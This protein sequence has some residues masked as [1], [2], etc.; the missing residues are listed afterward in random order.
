MGRIIDETG[1]QYGYWTVIKRLPRD[2][3]KG[4]VRWLCKCKCGTEKSICGAEL[5]RGR[6]KSCGC[7][8]ENNIIGQHFGRL[9]VLRKD[10]S[11]SQKVICQCD[12][13]AITSVYKGHL[14]TGA[15]TS[16]GKHLKKPYRDLSKETFGKLHPQYSYMKNEERYWYCQCECGN[17][18]EVSG[19]HLLYSGTSSCGCDTSSKGEKEIKQILKDNNLQYQR[20]YSFDDL[21]SPQSTNKLRFD[22]YV[23]SKWLI[24]FDGRQHFEYKNTWYTKEDFLLAKERDEVKNQYCLQHTIPL[25]RIPYTKLGKITLE[26]LM[27]ETS[28]FIYIG[29]D[30]FDTPCSN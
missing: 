30:D 29:G 16:C 3:T 21:Y 23:E 18:S 25:I 14:I 15:T 8:K 10:P 27:P 28:N 5:R 6:T 11:N 12:C 9:K 22:F 19:H 17:T 7:V 26:D 24:E 20:E 13:G 2:T 4:G 1:K